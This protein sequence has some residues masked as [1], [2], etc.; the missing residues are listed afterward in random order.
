MKNLLS[1]QN[2]LSQNAEVEADC[3]SSYIYPAKA[4][5]INYIFKILLTNC[6]YYNC[7]YCFNNVKSNCPRFILKPLQLAKLF[8]N[9][10]KKNKVEG[11]FLSSGIYKKEDYSQEK[12][13]ETVILLRKKLGYKG[14]IHAK[15]LPNASLYLIKELFHYVDRLS[16]NLEFPAQKYLRKV[17]HKKSFSD[18]F[19][20]LKYLSALNRSLSLSKGITTQFV[21]GALGESDREI[22][23]V[24]ERLYR[25]LKLKRVYYSC[26]LPFPNIPLSSVSPVDNLRVRRLYEADFL[27]R[28]YGFVSSEFLYDEYGNLLR[29]MDVKTASAF[30]NSH[31]FPINI[32]KARFDELIR[33]PTIGK[34]TAYQIIKLRKEAKINS[35]QKLV[36]I[37]INKEARRWICY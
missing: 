33:I 5:K 22:L 10:Y 29:N 18:L 3:L 36:K 34:K 27:I 7:G 17:S 15:I 6:C 26:F 31:L 23:S 13:L 12:I 35:F 20:R 21:V 1:A 9:L 8:M 14:Y 32:N 37:G 16:V 25:L 19:A 4:K 11:I 2:I 24:T 30:K 28:D